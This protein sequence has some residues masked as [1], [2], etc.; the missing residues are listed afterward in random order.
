[1]PAHLL[2]AYGSFLAHALFTICLYFYLHFYLHLHLFKYFALMFCICTLQS[3]HS[4]LVVML[5]AYAKHLCCVL[6]HCVYIW[7][8]TWLILITYTSKHLCFAPMFA[9]FLCTYACTFAFKTLPDA[10]YIY[11]I[12]YNLAVITSCW[13]PTLALKLCTLHNMHWNVVHLHPVP[14]VRLK[15]DWRQAFHQQCSNWHTQWCY[16]QWLSDGDN[17]D[18]DG[19]SAT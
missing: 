8:W 4:C 19:D 11:V 15:S 3:L 17:A 2:M 6:M 9:L 14:L 1:M 10:L 18:G 16:I 5:W 7:Y 12:M 13:A